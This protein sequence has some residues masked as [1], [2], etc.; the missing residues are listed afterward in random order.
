MP[1]KSGPQAS[2][3]RNTGFFELQTQLEKLGAAFAAT[4]AGHFGRSE[5]SE[6]E[7]RK[8]GVEGAQ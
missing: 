6:W 8:I 4:S 3:G 5:S 7:N 2:H 1:Q